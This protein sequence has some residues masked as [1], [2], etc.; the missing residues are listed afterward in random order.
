MPLRFVSSV[1]MILLLTESLC[2]SQQFPHNGLDYSVDDRS[3]GGVEG[4][5]YIASGADVDETKN[6]KDSGGLLVDV[7]T[8]ECLCNL[9]RIF[10]INFS[11]LK[12]RNICLP[13]YRKGQ[14]R[15]RNWY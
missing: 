3:N 13:T 9:Q 2:D 8:G 10:I 14:Q 11:I 5:N 12:I 1:L 7:P 15:K 4:L 6:A